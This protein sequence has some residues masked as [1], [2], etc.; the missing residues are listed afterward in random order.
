MTNAYTRSIVLIS[1]SISLLSSGAALAGAIAFI[2]AQK[3][4]MVTSLEV[5]RLVI[6]RENGEVAA[7]LRAAKDQTELVFYSAAQKEA[8]TLGI[9]RRI[10]SQYLRFFD[11]KGSLTGAWNHS[12]PSGDG[13]IYLGDSEKVRVQLGAEYSD[14][15]N[16]RPE[17]WGLWVRP[18]Y[19]RYSG[20]VDVSTFAVNEMDDWVAR[21]S[22][23]NKGKEVRISP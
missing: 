13:T 7:E 17:A 12:G 10:P 8:V 6:L 21:I 14:V 15:V 23:R 4:S 1:C 2:N 3:S 20:V 16:A 19:K 9:D 5:K 22:V 18:S 11:D